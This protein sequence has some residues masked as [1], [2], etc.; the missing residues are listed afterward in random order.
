MRTYITF[1]VSAGGVVAGLL[2]V[3]IL[4]GGWDAAAAGLDVL[5]GTAF[6][7]SLIVLLAR[8]ESQPPRGPRA[9][10]A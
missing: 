1:L 5:C 2:A 10:P 7:V 9:G 8:G 6:L 3:L 4:H